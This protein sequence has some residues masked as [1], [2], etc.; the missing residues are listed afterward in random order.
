MGEHSSWGKRAHASAECPDGCSR[1]YLT[2]SSQ[3]L[4]QGSA[5]V[6]SSLCIRRGMIREA[7]DPVWSYTAI[8]M[9]NLGFK[10]RAFGF[11]RHVL[12]FFF[13]FFFYHA[14][15]LLGSISGVKYV[16]RLLKE[17]LQ[18]PFPPKPSCHL[19]W[20]MK[21]DNIHFSLGNLFPS[22]LLFA[23]SLLFFFL[24]VR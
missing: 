2:S 4:T 5:V 23:H 22:F 17:P 6:S 13:F 11:W 21:Q 18:G 24:P 8:R 15:L 14:A 16:I 7:R 9:L 3:Q 19:R 10:H 20:D 12:F 1:S